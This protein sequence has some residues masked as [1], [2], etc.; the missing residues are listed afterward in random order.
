MKPK[1]LFIDKIEEKKIGEKKTLFRLKDWG[2]SRQRYW[3]CPVPVMYREDGKII[4]ALK[5]DLP[6][7][8]PPISK[9]SGLGNALEKISEWK[10][11]LCPLTGM[12]AIRETDTFDTYSF[13]TR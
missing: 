6:I 2:I 1:K 4:P 7:K 9:L 3:G 5:K 13:H 11:T 12:K 10:S 8:L